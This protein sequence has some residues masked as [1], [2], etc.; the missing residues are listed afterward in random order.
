MEKLIEKT[1]YIVLILVIAYFC[2]RLW[3]AG[4]YREQDTEIYEKELNKCPFDGQHCGI[5][6]K[7]VSK[8]YV[9]KVCQECPRYKNSK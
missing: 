6:G 5:I 4:R 8:N 3:K 1:P 9:T 2:Y 7:S